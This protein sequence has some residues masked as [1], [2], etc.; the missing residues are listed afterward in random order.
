ME[1]LIN[2]YN[3]TRI[4]K[5]EKEKE[6]IPATKRKGKVCQYTVQNSS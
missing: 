6:I 4:E 2:I 5:N 1:I 3:K